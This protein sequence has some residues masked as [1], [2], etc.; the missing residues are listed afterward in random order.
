MRISD[1]SSDVCS[2]DLKRRLLQPAF[3]ALLVRKLAAD[4]RL[5]LAPD[6]QDYA[7]QMWDVL[8]APHG[9]R[10]RAGPSGPVPRPE[11]TPQTYVKT[12]SKPLG[13]GGEALH[14]GGEPGSGGGHVVKT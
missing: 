4:G 3:A 10:N 12:R 9:L 5:H 7:E 6:W 2:S 8:D 1:W 13:H 14:A 11:L